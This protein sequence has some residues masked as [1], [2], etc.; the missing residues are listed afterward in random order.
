M[1]TTI[2]IDIGFR[3]TGI[4]IYCEDREEIIH[5]A[6]IRNPPLK[7]KSKAQQHW[8]ECQ[9]LSHELESLFYSFPDSEIIVESPSGGGK[10][11]IAVK[12]M[13]SSV[14]VLASVCH[15]Y[16]LDVILVTPMQLKKLVRAK[17]PVSKE[18]IMSLVEDKL[19][20]IGFKY[21]VKYAWCKDHTAD[22]GAVLLVADQMNLI[23]L[24]LTK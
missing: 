21:P 23:K 14:A 18:E 15:A 10:S 20:C 6:C 16:D 3:F 1:R 5:T 17:G 22:A 19:T 4:V 8:D 13:A 9:Y 24:K 7:R 2:A 12:S 11:S